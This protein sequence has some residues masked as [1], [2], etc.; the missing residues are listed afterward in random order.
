MKKILIVIYDMRIGGAQRSLLS[1]LQTLA[2]DARCGEYEIDVMPF[3]PV[4]EL[5]SQIPTGIRIRRPDNVLYWLAARMNKALFRHFS[6]RGL[7]GK[8]LWFLCRALRLL[9]QEGHVQQR[10]W[11]VWRRLVP[12]LRQ[13]YDV[14][15]S[16]IDG[17]ANYYVI[18]K[19]T[20][21]K[22]VLWLHSD[23]QQQGY[24]AEFDRRYY[25][26]CDAA[27]AVSPQCRQ[28]LSRA[29]EEYRDR[30]VELKN[31]SSGELILA[32]SL[33]GACPEYEGKDALRL[34]TVGRLHWMK[35]IDIAIKAAAQLKASGVTFV[36]L[37]IGEGEEHERLQN[38]ILEAGV[39]DC[40]HFLGARENPYVY[41]KNCD[42]LV[43]PSRV[44]GKSIALYEAQILGKP[45]VITAYPSAADAV[46]HEETGLIVEMDAQAVS[47]GIRRLACDHALRERIEN[48]LKRMPKGNESELDRYIDVMF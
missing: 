1:F 6:F 38:M 23:Y 42:I 7:A 16:Y 46:I 3:C 21:K 43:Q 37:V 20:A 34:L 36:W 2:K 31:I 32:Q 17:T 41:M 33:K 10:L 9:P 45:C 35:G 25:A 5:L 11:R 28:G 30:I 18:D 24:D 39:A 47:G 44:E 19:V 15:I 4:G 40:F 14:A 12:A 29:F 22:K 8:L 27:V 13:P 48:R 26:A